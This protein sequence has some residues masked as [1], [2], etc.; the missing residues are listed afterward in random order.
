MNLNINKL[1]RKLSPSKIS[2]REGTNKMMLSYV[3]GYVIEQE[4]NEIFDF[5]WSRE[6]PDMD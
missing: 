6:T 3:A 4:A 2:K 5:N 1:N